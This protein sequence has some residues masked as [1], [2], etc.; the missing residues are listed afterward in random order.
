[1]HLVI[2]VTLNVPSMPGDGII[3]L[4][5]LM[6]DNSYVTR[7]LDPANRAGSL[8]MSNGTTKRFT[9]VGGCGDFSANKKASKLTVAYGI[10]SGGLSDGN[11]NAPLVIPI[12]V[13][14]TGQ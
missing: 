4:Q 5:A 14:C 11:Q 6:A 12:N 13:T 8:T 2:D 7:F 1:M 10:Q 9:V 3:Y